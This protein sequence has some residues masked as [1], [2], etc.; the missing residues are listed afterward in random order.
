[1]RLGIRIVGN[2][3]TVLAG[4]RTNDMHLYTV[5]VQETYIEILSKLLMKGNL[6][7]SPSAQFDHKQS[8]NTS[9][10][11]WLKQY[12]TIPYIRAHMHFSAPQWLTS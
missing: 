3:Q 1:M 8:L 4:T 2:L 11:Y 9:Q 6:T 5:Q 12:M 10:T 7:N